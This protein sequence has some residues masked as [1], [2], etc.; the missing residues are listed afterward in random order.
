MEDMNNIKEVLVK[1]REEFEKEFAVFKRN[2][3]RRENRSLR[4]YEISDWWISKIS[5]HDKRVLEGVGVR[6]MEKSFSD[7]GNPDGYCHFCKDH[8]SQ[9]GGE[10]NNCGCD[11][12]NQAIQDIVVK[13]DKIKKLSTD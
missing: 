6:E 3:E 4:D 13:I 1:E 2:H 7:T 9:H 8:V 11:Y 12:Y 5:A 10:R